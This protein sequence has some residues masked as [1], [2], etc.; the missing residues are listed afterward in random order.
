MQ[1][2]E[3]L[4]T[5]NLLELIVIFWPGCT[6]VEALEGATLHPAQVLKLEHKKGTL[7]YGSDADLVLLDDDLNVHGT[8]IAGVPVWLSKTG[9]VTRTLLHKYQLTDDVCKGLLWWREQIELI[10]AYSY[11]NFNK[12]LLVLNQTFKFQAAENDLFHFSC[13]NMI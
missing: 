3:E 8:F 1:T 9:L 5:E 7:N 13:T 10:M 6:V 4:I 12:L 2:E 11:C